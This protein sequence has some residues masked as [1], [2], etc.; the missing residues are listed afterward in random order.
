MYVVCACHNP[1]LKWKDGYVC[2]MYFSQS[3]T[4]MEG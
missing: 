3:H 4:Q 2:N 1:T